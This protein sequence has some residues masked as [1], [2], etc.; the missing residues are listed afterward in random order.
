MRFFAK[1]ANRRPVYVLVGMF[2][3]VVGIVA[4]CGKPERKATGSPLPLTRQAVSAVD[5][6]IL[7]DY[8]GPK[9]QMI[10][11]DATTDYFCDVPELIKKKSATPAK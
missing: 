9:G 7:L 2:M 5:G 10:K 11:K 4:G 1:Q 3:L 8:P 6:M